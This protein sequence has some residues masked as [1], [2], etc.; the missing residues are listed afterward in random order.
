MTS[1]GSANSAGSGGPDDELSFHTADKVSATKEKLE[2]FYSN[3]KVR[4]GFCSRF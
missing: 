2:Q 4:W 1:I 3:G